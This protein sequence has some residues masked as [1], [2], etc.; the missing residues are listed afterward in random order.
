[1][2]IRSSKFAWILTCVAITCGIPL[3]AF[4]TDEPLQSVTLQL[5]W[6]HQFQFAGYYVTRELGFYREAGFDVEIRAGGPGI[7]PVDE[8]TD[9]R[10]DFGVDGSVAACL[11]PGK[12]AKPC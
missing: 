7:S 12:A 10:A 4:S 2:P 3:P 11:K 5:R 6:K 9:G 1:M 8:V